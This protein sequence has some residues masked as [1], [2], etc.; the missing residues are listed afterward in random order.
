MWKGNGLFLSED[1]WAPHWRRLE[2]SM[3]VTFRRHWHF[4]PFAHIYLYH[5]AVHQHHLL[6][7][8]WMRTLTWILIYIFVYVFTLYWPHLGQCC[9]HCSSLVFYLFISQSQSPYNVKAH[10]CFYLLWL[11]HCQY[12]KKTKK[13]KY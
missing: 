13:M 11:F 3:N 12:T 9:A 1:P 5:R 4:A 8:I 10:S 7:L 6:I 2:R